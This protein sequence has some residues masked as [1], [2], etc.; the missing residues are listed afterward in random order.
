MG[1]DFSDM[2]EI[3][4]LHAASDSNKIPIAIGVNSNLATAGPR[5]WTWNPK[6]A[7]VKDIRS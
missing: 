3:S 4:M 7:E 2:E 5:V 1:L 6:A